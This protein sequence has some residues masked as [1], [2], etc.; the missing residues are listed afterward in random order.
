[1]FRFYCYGDRDVKELSPGMVGC[2]CG[3][4]Q[5]P[6]LHFSFHSLLS[7]LQSVTT[8]HPTAFPKVPE[9]LHVF[10][11]KRY[12][13]IFILLDFFQ[14]YV[15]HKH[16]LFLKWFLSLTAKTTHSLCFFPTSLDPVYQSPLEVHLPLSVHYTSVFLMGCNPQPP[17]YIFSRGICIGASWRQLLLPPQSP[18]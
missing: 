16:S 10:K 4:R 5:P 1:M 17:V 14:H 18:L 3:H 6:G 13:L 15:P 9:D 12:F 2:P 8:L 7:S 11:S